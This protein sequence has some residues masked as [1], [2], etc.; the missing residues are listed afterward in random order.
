MN[1]REAIQLELSQERRTMQRQRLLKR[2]R[3]LE[4]ENKRKSVAEEKIAAVNST[5]V[6]LRSSIARKST[7]FPQKNGRPDA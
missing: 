7:Y 3:K 4:I 1:E 6:G 2:L 5:P